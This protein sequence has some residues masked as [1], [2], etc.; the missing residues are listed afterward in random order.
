MQV[1]FRIRVLVQVLASEFMAVAAVGLLEM[2][3]GRAVAPMHVL[4]LSNGLE[5]VQIEACAI[6]AE[7]I[8]V[9]PR[10]EWSAMIYPYLPVE[11]EYF[12]PN[13]I[14]AVAMIVATAPD[15]AVADQPGLYGPQG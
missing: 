10:F 12:A 15:D 13:V 9:L 1:P 14:N 8:D 3:S 4:F 2:T 7:V 11:R 5:V 6:A